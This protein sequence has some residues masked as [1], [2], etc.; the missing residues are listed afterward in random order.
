MED[1]S[2]GQAMLQER[3]QGDVEDF[4]F[5]PWGQIWVG[6]LRQLFRQV[7]SGVESVSS[8]HEGM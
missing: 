4:E 8:A 6:N 3:Q 2:S 1:T 5:L 7:R